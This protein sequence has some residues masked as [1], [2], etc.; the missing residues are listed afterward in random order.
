MVQNQ[1]APTLKVAMYGSTSNLPSFNFV[2]SDLSISFDD[3]Q[4][5]K[6]DGLKTARYIA[7]NVDYATLDLETR[8]NFAA[9][10]LEASSKI[11]KGAV[12]YLIDKY[13]DKRTHKYTDNESPTHVHDILEGLAVALC[14][15]RRMGAKA[16][17]LSQMNPQDLEHSQVDS[18][19]KN[20]VS[21]ALDKLGMQRVDYSDMTVK[22]AA[23]R[24]NKP[25][26]PAASSSSRTI[27][28]FSSPAPTHTSTAKKP[29]TL[30]PN[31]PGDTGK[32][33]KSQPNKEV[34]VVIFYI[35]NIF[36]KSLMILLGFYCTCC[37]TT[38]MCCCRCYS[39]P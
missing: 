2:E 33:Q 7:L 11:A 10:V 36:D 32:S 25:E 4:S 8:K 24:K 6:E 15:S 13:T 35:S 16:Y 39:C 34:R 9:Q 27:V 38:T 37:H 23:K 30:L 5:S 14:H 1:Q 31:E 26:A 12:M 19:V 20:V 29:I 18:Y 22:S 17:F 28:P 3:I 21:Y